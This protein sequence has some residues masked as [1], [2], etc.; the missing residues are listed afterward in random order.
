ML[1]FDPGYITA[2]LIPLAA[3]AI[4]LTVRRIRRRHVLERGSTD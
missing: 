3:L 2:A 1:K 4:W